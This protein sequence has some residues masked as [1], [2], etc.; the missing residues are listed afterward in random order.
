MSKLQ[1]MR[2]FSGGVVNQELQNR[3]DGRGVII[4]ANNVV[5]SWNGEMSRRTGTRWVRTLSGP[6]RII[7]FRAP[8]GNDIILL[9]SDGQLDG[10]VFADGEH[11]E[12][13][14]VPGGVAPTFPNSGWDGVVVNGDYTISI[15]SDAPQTDWGKGFNSEPMTHKYYEEGSLYTGGYASTTNVPA[16]IEISSANAQ[17]FKSCVIRWCNTC[18]GNHKGHYKGWEDPIIQYSDDGT[19][20][21]SVV[22]NV[23]NPYGFGGANEYRASYLYGLG[24]GQKT[25]NYIV[26]QVTNVNHI[27]PHA[28]WRIFMRLRVQNNQTFDGERIDLFVQNVEYS[29]SVMVPFQVQSSFFTTDNIY[30]IKYAQNFNA[31]DP[32]MILT[33][34]TDAALQISYAGGG[35]TVAP[36][37]NTLDYGVEGYPKCVAFYQNRLFFGGFSSEPTKVWGSAY[38]NFAD[39]TIP[40][41]IEPTSAIA[42]S[43][44]EIKSII[45]NLWGAPN[46]LYALSEDGVSMIDGGQIAVATDHIEFKL[47]NHEPVDSMTPTVKNDVMIYLGR[48]RQKIFMTDYDLVVQRFRAINLSKKYSNFLESGVRELHFVPDRCDLIYG[49]LSNGQMFGILFDPEQQKNGLFPMTT[50]G[51]VNDIQPIKYQDDTKLCMLVQRAGAWQLEFK[52]N[53][54]IQ[55]LMDFMSEQESKEYTRR[56]LA[57]DIYLDCATT[58]HYSPAVSIIS[59]LPY[60]A[61]QEVEV[62]ADG[63]YIGRKTL[64]VSSDSGLYAW[65]LDDKLVYTT[66]PT[67]TTSSVVYYANGEPMQGYLVSAVGA[68]DITVYHYV[69]QEV[70]YYAYDRALSITANITKASGES[71][72]PPLGTYV[73]NRNPALDTTSLGYNDPIAWDTG[74]YHVYTATEYSILSSMTYV[75]KT[76]APGGRG[77]RLGYTTAMTKT[78]KYSANQIPNLGDTIYNDDDSILGVVTA[79]EQVGVSG[80][81]S[82]TVNDVVYYQTPADNIV[83]QEEEAVYETYTRDSTS[84]LT[85]TGVSL[86]LDFEVS[87]ITV[88]VPY[89]SYM[90]VKFVTPYLIRKF[91]REIGVN[92]INTGYLEL[93]NSFNDLRPVLDNLAETITLDNMPVLLNGN[94]EKTLDK[95]AFETPY[96]IVNSNV[97]M[98]FMVTG[99]D[100]EIDYSNY[101]GGV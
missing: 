61:G 23:K 63:Q 86:L 53:K 43:C 91:P 35:L 15:S 34:G 101:Q 2:D 39:F 10:Y 70:S 74:A 31:S 5:S 71:G 80:I 77:V 76:W 84:D 36:Q 38:G 7:P 14:F 58:R 45:E 48:D 8:D 92:F 50:D 96:V 67:P 66:T 17:I 59:D 60:S 47:R 93:G 51:F 32:I 28:H 27:V 25:E 24:A 83:E 72:Y 73:F 97:G 30:D 20:W 21:T 44:V 98:P 100:Y 3:D 11:I 37:V 55:G 29:S 49:V 69:Q 95:Q 12:P 64:S 65:K 6:A 52:E 85:Y 57:R 81:Y 4:D 40:D 33:N 9:A 54:P 13:L 79:R 78:I 26:Y 62:F 46:A 22:T 90:V 75:Y 1:S 42:A 56:V 16:T 82:I 18:N 88:G 87:D 41:P 94:Y 99:I 89:Q 19:N 68:N